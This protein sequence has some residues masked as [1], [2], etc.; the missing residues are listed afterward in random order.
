MCNK[1]DS[2]ERGSMNFIQNVFDVEFQ[3][4]VDPQK[5]LFESFDKLSVKYKVLSQPLLNL[6]VACIWYSNL[7]FNLS[8][9]W[10]QI[11]FF[12]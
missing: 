6:K 9:L 11:D 5:I 3:K 2:F 10:N 12:I 4:I 1:C 8:F 7:K